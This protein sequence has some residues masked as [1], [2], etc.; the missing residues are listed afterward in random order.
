MQLGESMSL[1]L[2]GGRATVQC[3]ELF[4]ILFPLQ[5]MHFGRLKSSAILF[6]RCIEGLGVGAAIPIAVPQAI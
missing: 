2:C 5:Y 6:Y 1:Q 3:V 4:K